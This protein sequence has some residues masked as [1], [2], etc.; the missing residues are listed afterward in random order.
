[1]QDCLDPMNTRILA[2]LRGGCAGAHCASASGS[3]EP[4]V[5]EFIIYTPQFAISQTWAHR[6]FKRQPD[7]HKKK[8]YMWPLQQTHMKVR[9]NIHGT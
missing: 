9:R 8:D 1:M 5:W 7:V 6:D 2:Q 4:F 3:S